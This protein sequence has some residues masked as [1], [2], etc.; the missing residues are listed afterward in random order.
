VVIA[1]LPKLEVR[2]GMPRINGQAVE[3]KKLQVNYPKNQ[4]PASPAI[5]STELAADGKEVVC[6]LHNEI[7]I[8]EKWQFPLLPVT[9]GDPP[10]P[11][12]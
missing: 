8:R 1:E 7:L 2:I 6:K 12:K 4:G 9:P 5:M 11:A 10:A 3:V